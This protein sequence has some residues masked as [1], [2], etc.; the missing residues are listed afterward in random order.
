MANELKLDLLASVNHGAL[1]A[2]FDSGTITVD[3]AT[4]GETYY[5]LP[6]DGNLGQ[7]PYRYRVGTAESDMP[8]AEP[9]TGHRAVA[10][11]GWLLVRNL[12]VNY[13]TYGP[14][15]GGVMVPLGRIEPSDVAGQPG[16]FIALRL[17][18]GVTLRWAANTD[19]VEV[20]MLLIGN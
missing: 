12:G 9:V 14:K 3:Q 10:T 18:P 15:S 17:S 1:S 16:E 6:G 20:A 4:P 7:S 8:T 13:I 11:N 2:T 19:A 5:P